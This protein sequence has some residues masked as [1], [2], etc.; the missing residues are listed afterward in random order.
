LVFDSVPRLLSAYSQRR[1]FR[2]SAQYTVPPMPFWFTADQYPRLRSIPGVR[3]VREL[4]YPP[5]RGRLVPWV[6]RQSYRLSAL[7]RFRAAV[8]LVEFS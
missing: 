4:R 8:T 6:T 5:G 2:L 3:N 7:A 1:G